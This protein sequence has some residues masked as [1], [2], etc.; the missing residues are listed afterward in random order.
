[1]KD[2][3]TL[4]RVRYENIFPLN[5]WLRIYIDSMRVHKPMNVPTNE[6]YISTIIVVAQRTLSQCMI[7]TIH[8]KEILN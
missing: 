1:M 4:I 8:T 3:P 5:I 6:V 7:G 2:T